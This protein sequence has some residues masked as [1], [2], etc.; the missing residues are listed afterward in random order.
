ML[1]VAKVQKF[2]VMCPLV[3]PQN[4]QR[5]IFNTHLNYLKKLSGLWAELS[6]NALLT[7][8]HMQQ[9]FGTDFAT[10]H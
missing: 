9:V 2:A 4:Q 1:C 7:V 8:V 5:Y 10:S 6:Y 3:P